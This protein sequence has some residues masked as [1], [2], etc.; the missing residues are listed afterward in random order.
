MKKEQSLPPNIQNRKLIS[1]DEFIKVTTSRSQRWDL[2]PGR[3]AAGYTCLAR[4]LHCLPRALQAWDHAVLYSVLF[5][6]CPTGRIS[7]NIEYYFQAV[8]CMMACL[9]CGHSM[10]NG[11]WNIPVFPFCKRLRGILSCSFMFVGASDHRSESRSVVSDSCNPLDYTVHG[12]L[13]ARVLEWFFS[14]PGDLPSPGIK[15]MSPT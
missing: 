7:L 2:S 10:L 15:L 14:S 1:R 8:G 6:Q 3:K 9:C 11:P 12:I 4:M 13:Q 5:S